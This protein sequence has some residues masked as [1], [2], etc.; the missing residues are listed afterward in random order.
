M[1]DKKLGQH[2]K[3]GNALLLDLRD[4]AGILLKD[5]NIDAEKA[6]QIANE[7]MYIIAKHWA[8][9]HYILLKLTVFLQMSVIFRFTTSLM[10]ITI[11]N[12]HKNM[13]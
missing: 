3:R 10:V 12:L 13:I 5:A 4:Q 2:S 11:L 1:S 6:S 9:S 7:L 8:V